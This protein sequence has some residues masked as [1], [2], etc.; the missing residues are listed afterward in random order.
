MAQTKTEHVVDGHKP[1]KDSGKR[2]EFGTGSRR[3]TREGKGR[4]DLIPPSVLLALARHLEDGSAKYGDRNWEK[5]QPISRYFDSALRHMCK[6]WAGYVDEPHLHAAFWNIMAI[7]ETEEQVM[8]GELP[9][10]LDDHPKKGVAPLFLRVFRHIAFPDNLEDCWLWTAAN[11]GNG[12]GRLAVSRTKKEYPHRIVCEQ[13]H[14]P[15][16]FEGA[17][18]LH[19]CDNGMCVNPRH[20]RWGTQQENNVEAI[21]KGHRD[22]RLSTAA[23]EFIKSSS[24]SPDVLAE[25]FSISIEYVLAIKKHA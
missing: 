8:N 7:I 15:S 10:E 13:V 9:K 6:Y 5:G 12:Y 19:S 14:G 16:P 2:Q 18:V 24:Q 20:L 22:T 25:L 17:C 4:F 23:R 21:A 1:I 3:D 11:N